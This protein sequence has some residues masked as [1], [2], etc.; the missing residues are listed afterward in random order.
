M[1]IRLSKAFKVTILTIALIVFVP[2][3]V[4]SVSKFIDE[5]N[6]TDEEVMNLFC[7]KVDTLEGRATDE[8]CANP[9]LYRQHIE[10]PSECLT[11]SCDPF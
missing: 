11:F 3:A 7:R 4:Y 9:E 8:Y 5:Q 6:T 2:F 1:N 10:D